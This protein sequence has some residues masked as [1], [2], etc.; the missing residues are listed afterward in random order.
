MKRLLLALTVLYFPLIKAEQPEVKKLV[1]QST[2]K[3]ESIQTRWEMYEKEGKT[4][5]EGIKKERKTDLI[6]SADGSLLQF[7]EKVG[8]EDFLSIE[9]VGPC[10]IVKSH[11]KGKDKI[12]SHKIGD[13]PWL[14]EFNF[15]LQNF[16]KQKT[17]VLEFYIIYPKDLSMQEMVV[18]KEIVEEIE[19]AGKKQQAQKVKITLTGFKKQFWKAQAWFDLTTG[20][21]VQYRANEGPR[22]PYTDIE[23]LEGGGPPPS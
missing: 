4:F 8:T 17:K 11:Q 14:Q 21:L 19:V 9:K 6:Y 22:T 2:T 13:K 18:T 20:L 23:M 3:G 5:M 16:I 15:G 12:L 1:Y 7:T 10:L